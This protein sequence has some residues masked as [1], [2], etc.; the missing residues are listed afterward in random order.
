MS[1][2]VVK[3]LIVRPDQSPSEVHTN[4]VIDSETCGWDPREIEDLC[5]SGHLVDLDKLNSAA[6]AALNPRPLMA[7]QPAAGDLDF[8]PVKL[9]KMKFDDLCNLVVDKAR[10]QPP[11]SKEECIAIL[12]QHYRPPAEKTE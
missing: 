1:K 8:D 10:V 12:S 7:K 4:T 6:L 3:G 5:E 9:R 11:D 2:L